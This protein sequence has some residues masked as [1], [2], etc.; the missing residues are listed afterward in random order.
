[1]ARKPKA[2]P[3]ADQS[4]FDGKAF[5]VVRL[6]VHDLKRIEA[7]ELSPTGDL[8][9][10][11]GQNGNGK[12]SLID[13]IWVALGGKDAIPPDP[14]RHGAD[15]AAIELDLGDIIVRRSIEKDRSSR[16]SVTSREGAIYKSPQEML[17]ALV[18]DLTFDPLAFCK[19]KAKDQVAL[20]R[21]FVP[22][23]DFD[24]AEADRLKAYD[25]RTV[26]NR[27]LKSAEARVEHSKSLLGD[28][29]APINLADLSKSLDEA[30]ERNERVRAA[31]IEFDGLVSE[32]RIFADKIA[33]LTSEL[34]KAQ[35]AHK[36]VEAEIAQFPEIPELQDTKEMRAKYDEAIEINRQ[37]AVHTERKRQI[38]AD[39][40]AVKKLSGESEALTARIKELDDAVKDAI[41]KAALPVPDLGFGDGFVT[42]GGVPFEQ[43]SGAEQLKTA[44]ALGMAANPNIK[45]LLIRDGSLLDDANMKALR[46]MAEAHGFQIWIERVGNQVGEAGVIIEAGKIKQASKQ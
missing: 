40:A 33:A 41:S 1:M 4:L 39:E 9:E 24:Q 42:K 25:A 38:A 10:V 32:R 15:M 18:G 27:D 46:E 11:G 12:T 17:N 34:E 21:Q 20:L 31:K 36:S 13:S 2:A 26:A 8:V 6:S 19:M 45:I 3:A 16:L 44:V 22:D 29:P 14:V 23:F 30:D 5:K 35:A 7:V 43:A 37:A 28:A